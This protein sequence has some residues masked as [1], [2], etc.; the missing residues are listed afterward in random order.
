MR[1]IA[2]YCFLLLTVVLAGVSVSA[3]TLTYRSNGTKGGA[4][5]NDV[6][7]FTKNVDVLVFGVN[8]PSPTYEM[9]HLWTLS[10]GKHHL[11]MGGI[12]G[13]QW[14][15]SGKFFAEPYVLVKAWEGK[16]TITGKLFAYL[17]LNGGGTFVGADEL[18]L[19]HKVSSEVEVGVE[20]SFFKSNP[21][22]LMLKWGPTV[23]FAKGDTSVSFRYLGLGQGADSFRLTLSRSL[24]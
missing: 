20:G 4:P 17:P 5:S 18:S 9:G 6:M 8:T 16:T 21:S 11:V 12:Y 7:V 22:P 23:R 10:Q 13:S 19:T 3:D 1:K 14:T 2:C 15:G 24:H